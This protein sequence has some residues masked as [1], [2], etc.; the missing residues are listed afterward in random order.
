MKLP[1]KKKYFDMIKSGEKTVEYRDAHI[2]F[3][4]EETGEQLKKEI[5]DVQLVLQD[6]IPEEFQHR[7]LFDDSVIIAFTLSEDEII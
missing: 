1:I 4:C 3:V 2:T 7:N 6:S 5:D